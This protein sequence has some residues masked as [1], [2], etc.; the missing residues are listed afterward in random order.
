MS[1]TNS[2]TGSVGDQGGVVNVQFAL[3]VVA[4]VLG[5]IISLLFLRFFCNVA[6]DLCILCDPYEARRTAIEFRNRYFPC[7]KRRLVVPERRPQTTSRVGQE[8]AQ[9]TT[10]QTAT[11]D[12]DTLLASLPDQLRLRVLDALL[13]G[14]VSSYPGS[15]VRNGRVARRILTDYVPLTACPNERLDTA[16][17]NVPRSR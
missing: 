17:K 3:T 4:V 14:K 11:Y 9:S 15:Y 8:S 6:I 2:G 16:W 7:F 1:S 5:F 13:T 10:N 12:V